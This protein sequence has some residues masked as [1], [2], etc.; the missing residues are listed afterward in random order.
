MPATVLIR[1][2]T[3]AGPT[4]TDITSIN[5]RANTTDAHTPAD[6]SNPIKVPTSGTKYSYWVVT[7]LDATVT[8]AGTINNIKWYTDGTNSYGTGITCSVGTATGYTQASGT[9]GDT[10]IVL[11]VGNYATWTLGNADAFTYNSGAPLSVTGSISNPTTG[12]FG[13][14][15]VYQVNVETTAGPGV[16]PATPETFTWQFDE[17]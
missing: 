5:T 17:T 12:Q 3:G 13:D 1:R 4:A 2:L 16:A 6:T 15:V 8:P 7:R 11:S 10:G 9:P 14:R